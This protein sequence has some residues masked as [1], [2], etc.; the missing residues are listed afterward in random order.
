MSAGRAAALLLLV[1]A[2]L[3]SVGV[4]IERD[5][6]APHEATEQA[7]TDREAAERRSATPTEESGETAE[8]DHSAEGEDEAVLGV[9][10]E[11]PWTV[12]AAVAISATLAVGLWLSSRRWLAGV[13]AAF[14]VIFAAFDI[15]EV[16][17]QLTEHR[18][19]LVAVAVVLAV[20]HLAAGALAGG[21][22]RRQGRARPRTSGPLASTSA[23]S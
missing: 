13:A 2:A 21:S 9:D 1:T 6:G 22:S 14:A 20:G 11:S 7:T 10:L 3:F 4:I 16:F 15:D 18:A 5:G 19:G 23:R 12:V 17:H 8:R